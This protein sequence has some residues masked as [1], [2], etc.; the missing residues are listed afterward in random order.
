MCIITT[1]GA[2]TKDIQSWRAN[3]GITPAELSE[4]IKSVGDLSY[5]Q[6]ENFVQFRQ[7]VT[8]EALFAFMILRSRG[9][10]VGNT[11]GGHEVE[12]LQAGIEGCL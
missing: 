4:Y 2:R 6:V 3:L 10:L 12:G 11:D 7:K 8:R 5:Q 9:M 1:I